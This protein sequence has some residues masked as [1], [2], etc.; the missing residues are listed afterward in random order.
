VWWRRHAWIPVWIAVFLT[1]AALL[2]LRLMDDTSVALVLPP[3]LT[4]M[5]VLFLAVLAV[6]VRASVTRSVARA[7]AG[8]GS[9][10]L[11]AGLLA[12]TMIHVIGQR[13]CPERMGVDRGVQVAA[14][15][16]DTW[17][18]GKA[19]PADVWASAAVADAWRARV[20]KLTLIDYQVVDSGC[21]ERLAPVATKETWH[22]FRVTVQRGDDRFSKVVTVHTHATRGDWH[23]TEVEGPES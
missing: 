23:I 7:L 22:E 11:A 16:L 15:M 20:G 19:A 4:G 21:W 13:S 5:I 17:R 8:G 6:A 12:L 3:L 18:K 10:L 14:Q 1:P 9:A 2:S